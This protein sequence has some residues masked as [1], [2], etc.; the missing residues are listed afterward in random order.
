MTVNLRSEIVYWVTFN[1]VEVYIIQD[2]LNLAKLCFYKRYV[3]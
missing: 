1:F 2:D 3:S